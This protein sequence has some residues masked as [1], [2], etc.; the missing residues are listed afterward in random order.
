MAWKLVYAHDADG[1]PKAPFSTQDRQALASEA[2][3]GVA[4]R[5]AVTVPG[6]GVQDLVESPDRVF[7]DKGHVF[8]LI[9]Q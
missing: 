1:N 3:A 6:F 8:A 4:V 7:V 5:F 2:A 9:P